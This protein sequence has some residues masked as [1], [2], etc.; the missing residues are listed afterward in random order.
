MNKKTVTIGKNNKKGQFY[1]LAALVIIFIILI[2]SAVSNYSKKN[3]VVKVYDFGEELRIEG[4]NVLDYGVISGNQTISD[5]IEKHSVYAKSG[6]DTS[7]IT[8]IFGDTEKIT[9]RTYQDITQGTISV[10]GSQLDITE[11]GYFETDYYP[12][13]GENKVKVT[14]DDFEREFELNPGENFFFVINQKFN[15]EEFAVTG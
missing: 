14:I 10:G 3:D 8:Y 12:Q 15:G 2:F 11:G 1:L 6:G 4:D 9:V 13:P 5:F 7:K